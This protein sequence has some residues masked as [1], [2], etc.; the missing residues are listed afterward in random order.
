MI[1]MIWMGLSLVALLAAIPA[2]VLTDVLRRP[3]PAPQGPQA[4]RGGMT[5]DGVA[6][7]HGVASRG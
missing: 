1:D 2:T 3:E 6:Y 7:V 4:D 5:A